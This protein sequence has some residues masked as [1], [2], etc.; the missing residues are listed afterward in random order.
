MQLLG[1]L[2]SRNFGGLSILPLDIDLEHFRSIS[3]RLSILQNNLEN[4]EKS[5]SL[6]Y[7]TGHKM[8]NRP[9]DFT[10]FTRHQYLDTD[11]LLSVSD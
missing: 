9:R 7:R 10:K 5:W 6:K 4:A 3:T 2:T 11:Q 1:M 8:R